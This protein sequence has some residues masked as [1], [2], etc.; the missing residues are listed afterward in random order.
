VELELRAGFRVLIVA[1]ADVLPEQLDVVLSL[2]IV[3][4]ER[5]L[6]GAVGVA[7]HT[8]RNT[9]PGRGL[10]RGVAQRLR[11]GVRRW[12]PR[13]SRIPRTGPTTSGPAAARGPDGARF[14]RLVLRPTA[15]HR[16]QRARAGDPG[17]LAQ[18]LPPPQLGTQER[19]P[20]LRVVRFARIL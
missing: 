9:I 12:R 19:A 13:S 1:A 11:S 10:E 17:E 4:E 14:T 7:G 6:P 18:R 2:A 15:E 3:N 20:A 8:R 5:A 16:H